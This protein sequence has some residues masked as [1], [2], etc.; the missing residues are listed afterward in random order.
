MV[1]IS[2]I[3]STELVGKTYINDNTLIVLYGNTPGIERHI[4]SSGV[5][6]NTVIREYTKENDL[7]QTADFLIGSKGLEAD[8]NDNTKQI[9]NTATTLETI[10]LIK[11]DLG[12]IK[13]VWLRA[14]IGAINEGNPY[15]SVLISDDDVTYTNVLTAQ[16]DSSGSATFTQASVSK[17][18]SFRYL[19]VTCYPASSG[20]PQQVA[21]YTLQIFD[22]SDENCKSYEYLGN[23]SFID[24]IVKTNN[25]K[26][27]VI[28]FTEDCY[29][30]IVD[31]DNLENNYIIVESD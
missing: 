15:I 2:K 13:N 8:W 7:Y 9:F 28:I 16:G 29:Y 4:L 24:Y 26:Y 22:N 19:K 3:N 30:R 14:I 10:T 6:I 12:E 18:Y 5:D 23:N 21:V 17:Y 11:I 27:M 25:E 31:I 20:G 1:R